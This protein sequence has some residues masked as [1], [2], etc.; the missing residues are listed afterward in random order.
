NGSLPIFI[1]R[2][3][4]IEEIFRVIKGKRESVVLV[5]PVGVGK[6]ALLSHLAILMVKNQ[7]PD[8]LKQKRLLCLSVEHLIV[9]DSESIVREQFL[10]MLDE[11]SQLKNIF[12]VFLHVNELPSDLAA[13]LVNFLSLT[14]TCIIGTMTSFPSTEQFESSE[15]GH[16][17]YKIH[18]E[19]PDTHTTIQILAS[20]MKEIELQQSI[21]F[22]H[23]AL[24]SCVY[25]SERYM[26]ETFLP[27]KAIDI[28]YE[29]ACYVR[30]KRGVNSHVIDEDVAQIISIKTGVSATGMMLDRKKNSEK[31]LC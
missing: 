6:N 22:S 29:V 26:H 25:F 20:H 7:V 8:E 3:N 2:E 18:V 14:S 17:F 12:L 5:G 16:L 27:K 4:E 15:L 23:F 1:G 11:V 21:T 9:S 28:A 30:Q 10:L 24:E 19:E 13:L 31:I